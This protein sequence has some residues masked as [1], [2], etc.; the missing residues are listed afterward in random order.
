MVGYKGTK[1]EEIIDCSSQEESEILALFADLGKVHVEIPT[2]P[3]L[4]AALLPD[5]RR[6]RTQLDTAMVDALTLAP[7]HLR[8]VLAERVR[9]AVT[10]L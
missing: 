7:E 4:I 8:T 10:R 9:A 3:L 5:L 6:F 1:S 2:D